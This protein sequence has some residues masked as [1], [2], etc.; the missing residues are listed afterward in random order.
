MTSISIGIDCH[1]PPIDAGPAPVTGDIAALLQPVPQRLYATQG[2]GEIADAATLRSPSN[3]VLPGG[4]ILSVELRVNGIPES[5]DFA[6]SQGDSVAVHVT[7]TG[8][9]TAT[10]TL[11]ASVEFAVRISDEADG[12]AT[13]EFNDIVP[14]DRAFNITAVSEPWN[15]RGSWPVA[16]SRDAYERSTI[17]LVVPLI[18]GGS[19]PG[20]TPGF[21]GGLYGTDLSGASTYTLQLDGVDISGF[22]R[23][24]LATVQGYVIDTAGDLTLIELHDGVAVHSSAAFA[25]TGPV[26]SYTEVGATNN[27]A[28]NLF[29]TG[30]IGANSA[31]ALICLSFTYT[32]VTNGNGVLF[33]TAGGITCAFGANTLRTRVSGST[34]VLR[35]NSDTK[36]IGQNE[37]ANALIAVDFNGVSRCYLQIGNG[38]WVE[39]WTVDQTGEDRLV[40]HDG[41][42]V[43]VMGE[44]DGAGGRCPVIHYRTAVW[45]GIPLPDL[46]QSAV[47]DAFFS[48]GATVDPATAIAAYGTPAIDVYGTAATLNGATGGNSG[49][50]GNLTVSGAFS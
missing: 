43:G 5:D 25:V 41:A 35:I 9:K 3:Y 40:G 37:R 50:Y 20:D 39:E 6:V 45:T 34:G 38:A 22:A 12:T 4:A 31:T 23:V 24:S 48:G 16:V 2:L 44:A 15:T 47:R 30:A 32:R 26:S 13:L 18:S 1:A 29:G 14:G 27:K 8:L 11:C 28:V 10:W 36:I 49:S 42:G 33:Q 46:A 21:A 19:G 7:G 17:S